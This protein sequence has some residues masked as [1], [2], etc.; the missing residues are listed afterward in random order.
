MQNM[1]LGSPGGASK[2]RAFIEV[3][4]GSVDASQMANCAVQ[5]EVIVITCHSPFSS[6][7]GSHFRLG[8]RE[9][10]S[11]EVLVALANPTEYAKYVKYVKYEILK[12][13]ANILVENA[14]FETQAKMNLQLWI[15][16]CWMK[17]VILEHRLGMNWHDK[18]P[19][20]AGRPEQTNHISLENW[21]I[22]ARQY[23]FEFLIGQSIVWS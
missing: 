10:R 14:L 21:L 22:V 20:T 5:H 19:E 2:F 13:K 23:F 6:A 8:L 16:S 4:L 7:F 15:N 18:I 12:Y 9:L 11:A 3:G 17:N 1:Y